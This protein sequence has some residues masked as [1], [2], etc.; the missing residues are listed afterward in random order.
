MKRTTGRD[1]P[2]VET[3]RRPGDAPVL[4]ADNAKAREALGWSPRWSLDDIIAHA[5]AWHDQYEAAVFG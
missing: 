2:V 5:W 4:V 3:G 1:F